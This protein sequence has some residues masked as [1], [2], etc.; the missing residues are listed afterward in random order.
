MGRFRAGFGTGRHEHRRARFQGQGTTA[1]DRWPLAWGAEGG[2]MARGV[3]RWARSLGWR[4]S[5]VPG[6]DLA[7][8]GL[9]LPIS[10][11]V[12]DPAGGCGRTIGREPGDGRRG[13]GHGGP[14]PRGERVPLRPRRRTGAGGA[15][16]PACGG[17]SPLAGVPGFR[18]GLLSASRPCSP[19]GASGFVSCATTRADSAPSAA[20][21]TLNNG[22]SAPRGVVLARV[23]VGGS[24][25]FVMTR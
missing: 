12:F 20:D 13:P 3:L 24:T 21:R 9:R 5:H 15:T 16:P 22:P 7:R 2:A 23:A 19:R 1:V 11:N 14:A 25:G 10:M 8:L 17:A 4:P 18:H 6:P